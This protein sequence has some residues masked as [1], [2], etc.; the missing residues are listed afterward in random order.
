[1]RSTKRRLFSYAWDD[2]TVSIVFA[3]DANEAV[4]IL[5]EVG[6]ADAD[7]MI[8]IASD[9]LFVTITRTPSGQATIDDEYSLAEEQGDGLSELVDETLAGYAA[10]P[11]PT[12][13][14]I[15]DHERENDEAIAAFHAARSGD[16]KIAD[17]AI[18]KIAEAFDRI[19]ALAREIKGRPGSSGAIV[20]LAEQGLD[21][22]ANATGKAGR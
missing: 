6:E 22:I 14:E 5:D 20:N 16:D 9:H 2:D 8:P 13:E 7:K 17:M 15:A 21:V 1:M 4:H 10:P 19:R 11:E 18:A 3:A 12:A